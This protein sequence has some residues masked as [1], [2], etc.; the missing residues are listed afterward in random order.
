MAARL[1]RKI[2]WDPAKEQVVGDPEAAASPMMTRPY[3][4]P[5]KLG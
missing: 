1:G 4:A 2:Q 3:R 5:W